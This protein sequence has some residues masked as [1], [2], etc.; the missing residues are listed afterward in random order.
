[1]ASMTITFSQASEKIHFSLS[2]LLSEKM[3]VVVRSWLKKTEGDK[4]FY[5]HLHSLMPY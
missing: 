2:L 5:T 4:L 1:M 3:I